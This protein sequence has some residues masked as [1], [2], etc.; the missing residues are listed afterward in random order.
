[1]LHPHLRRLALVALACVVGVALSIASAR[2][3][4]GMLYGVSPADPLTL[5]GV[6]GIV[7]LAGLLGWTELPNGWRCP[8]CEEAEGNQP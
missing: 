8:D 6:V 4:A 2:L 1:M 3:L 5:S 7:A